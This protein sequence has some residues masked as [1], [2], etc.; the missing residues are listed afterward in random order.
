MTSNLDLKV[1]G[2]KLKTLRKSVGLTRKAIYINHGF[3]DRTIATWEYGTREMKLSAF[4]R[5]IRV[6]ELYGVKVSLD[7]FLK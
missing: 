2:N 3:P 6:F 1:L 4:V 5:Y 7:E